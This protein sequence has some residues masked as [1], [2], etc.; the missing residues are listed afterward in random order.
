MWNHMV[1]CDNMV[2]R[3][4]RLSLP[5]GIHMHV[6]SQW[7]SIPIHLVIWYI[8]NPLPISFTDYASHY[9]VADENYFGMYIHIYL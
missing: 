9:I 4:A 6:A 8:T 5:K 2:H 7:F 1:E 3:I